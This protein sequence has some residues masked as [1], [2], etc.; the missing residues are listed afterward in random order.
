MITQYDPLRTYIESTKRVTVHA[1]SA[2]VIN[3]HI[4]FEFFETPLHCITYF[5]GKLLICCKYCNPDCMLNELSS[6]VIAWVDLLV[7]SVNDVIFLRVLVVSFMTVALMRIQVNNHESLHV[8]PLL[9]IS[10][11]EG[12]VRVNAEAAPLVTGGMMEASTKVYCP[13]L[14]T[15]ETSRLY[16]SLGCTRHRIQKTHSEHPAREWQR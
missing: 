8:V 9:H 10:C 5:V 14:L 13:A 11:Y 1:V 16:T 15:C 4:W 3:H 12:D 2:S 7:V 6:I